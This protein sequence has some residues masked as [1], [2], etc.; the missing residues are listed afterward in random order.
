MAE[1]AVVAHVRSFDPHVYLDIDN[2]PKGWSLPDCM[3]HGVAAACAASD[4]KLWMKYS[5]YDPNALGGG[6]FFAGVEFALDDW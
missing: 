6:G 1:Q 3:A 2:G 4:R 5:S